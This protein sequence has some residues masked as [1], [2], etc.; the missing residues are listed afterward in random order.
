[1]DSIFTHKH[2]LLFKDSIENERNKCYK[3]TSKSGSDFCEV[4]LINCLF[5]ECRFEC[6]HVEKLTLKY[7]YL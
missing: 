5:N 3:I 2:L 4:Q 6:M 1:M 7:S